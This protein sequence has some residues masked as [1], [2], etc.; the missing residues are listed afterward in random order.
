MSDFEQYSN[1]FQLYII[2]ILV[3]FSHELGQML[4]RYDFLEVV[5]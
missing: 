1:Q 5:R 4:I 3:N 2:S